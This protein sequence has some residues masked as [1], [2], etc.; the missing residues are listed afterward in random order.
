MNLDL[1]LLNLARLDELAGDVL[2]VLWR[3]SWQAA[4]LASIVL[5]VQRIGRDRLSARWR[6]NLWLLVLLRLIVPV[7][8]Q[9]PLSVFNLSKRFT[10]TETPPAAVIVNQAKQATPTHLATPPLMAG[11][12]KHLAASKPPEFRWRL[13]LATLWL[14]GVLVALARIAF[15][16]LRLSRDVRRMAVVD[17]P[18]VSELLQ[19]CA[20]ELHVRRRVVTLAS[21][22]LPAPALMGVLRPRLLLPSHVLSDFAPAELRLILLHE[23]AHLKR[24]DVLTNWLVALL[25]ALHWFNPML[26]LAFARLR[27]DRELATDELV[28]LRTG[29]AER[30]AYGDT[31]LKL[32]QSLTANHHKNPQPIAGA[33]GILE[34]A[35][36]LRRRITMIAQFHGSSKRWTF[37]AAACMLILAGLGL[38]DAVRGDSAAPTTPPESKPA[39]A[40]A[41]QGVADAK[42]EVAAKSVAPSTRP[43]DEKLNAMIE[44]SIAKMLAKS[45]KPSRGDI[46]AAMSELGKSIERERLFFTP[47]GQA[48]NRGQVERDVKQATHTLAAR[49]DATHPSGGNAGV[50]VETAKVHKK[51]AETAPEA[52]FAAVPF[53]DTIDFLRDVTGLN[54]FVDWRGLE[55]AGI[56]RNTPITV[57]MQKVP[58]ETVLRYVLRDAGHQVKLDYAV[59]DGIVNISTAELISAE[60]QVRVYDIEPLVLSMPTTMPVGT[61]DAGLRAAKVEKVIATIRDAIAPDSWRDAGGTAGS[62]RELN[63]KLVVTQTETN[64][65]AIAKLLSELSSGDDKP[66]TAQRH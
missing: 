29:Q 20:N 51:L 65:A 37:A 34:R 19:S 17:D 63:G 48:A 36:T 49:F 55:A 59:I 53:S 64:H 45:P 30:G 10:R 28:L 14:T 21:D 61:P 3:S 13:I 4:V 58:F 18:R 66:A 52:N 42:A 12:P 27:A 44:D 31:I 54:I 41:A 32:L 25:H 15:A 1:A 16:T 38:T 40:D 2:A 60:T 46:E 62:I 35:H 33:V 26:A 8:P 5:V 6:Y 50:P 23:L 56:D 7:T 43:P 47:Q 22:V 39:A 57:R 24:H 9:S 11:A